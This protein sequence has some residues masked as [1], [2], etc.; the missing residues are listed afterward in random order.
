MKNASLKHMKES[1]GWDDFKTFSEQLDPYLP[2][3]GEGDTLATQ[4]ATAVSK[5][6]YKWFNDGDVYDNTYYLR[7]WANDLSSYANWLE[8]YIPD[9][10]VLLEIKDC[11]SEDDYVKLLYKLCDLVVPQLEE[12]NEKPKEGSVYDCDGPFV[13]E[14]ESEEESE[15]DEDDEWDDYDDEYYDD[16]YYDDEY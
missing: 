3:T 7:G 5:L 2:P 1:Y 11:K 15:D 12:L 4:A 13:F 8:E 9:A 14:E 16:E 10:S 6:V